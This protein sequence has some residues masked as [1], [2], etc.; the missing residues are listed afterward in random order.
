MHVSI[1]NNPIKGKYS[2][3]L[4]HKEDFIQDLQ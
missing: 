3:T 1:D 4:K 2:D